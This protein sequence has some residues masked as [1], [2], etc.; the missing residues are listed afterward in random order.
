[1]AKSDAQPPLIQALLTQS[2]FD[3][4]AEARELIETHISWV[5]LAGD[6]VYKIKKP[7]E[8]GF[9]D[10]STLEKRRY[11]CEEELRLNRRLAAD[12]YLEVVAIGGTPE[13][14]Q[15][16]ARRDILEYAVKMRRFPQGAQLD[17][18]L[19]R[20]E[21]DGKK[22]D[23]FARMVADFHGCAAIADA[24]SNFG[25]PP[26]IWQ[27]VEENFIQIREQITDK[28]WQQQLDRLEQWSRDR[29][30][31]LQPIMVQRKRDGFIRECHGDLHLRNLAWIDNRAVAFD[32]I[33]FNPGLSWIDVISDIAFL[34]MDLR[35]KGEAHLAQRFLNG[36]LEISGDYEGL[37]LLSFYL[38]Y[39][40]MVRAKVAALRFGQSGIN[41]SEKNR[42]KNE[43]VVYLN[44]AERCI[45]KGERFLVTTRGVSA[46]GKSKHSSMLLEWLQAIRLRSD[47]ERKRLYG[48]RA[49]ES[50]KA[51]PAE[52]IYSHDASERTYARLKQLAKLTVEA[53]YPVIIDATSLKFEQRE[54]FYQLADELGVPRVLVEFTAPA[55]VLRQRIVKRKK[56]ASDA[57]LQVLEYQLSQWQPVTPNEEPY[58]LSVDTSGPLPE[59]GE[60][61]AALVRDK[62]G[63]N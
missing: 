23:A 56:G 5:I 29:F 45:E 19:Q 35:E 26:R 25:I 49:D 51:N 30:Q 28:H 59:S 16:N 38:V 34:I 13:R 11:N 24:E 12:I 31:Q 33:E 22:I 2:C 50:G 4:P 41:D 55:E 58:R 8:F 63:L 60:R 27:P 43:F 57:D 6:Y 42:A 37:S 21:L 14:P 62:L 47:V 3:H 7:V 9:L 46:S 53:G 48:L 36:Y 17:R 32:C 1:M 54:Q 20:H 10:F 61:L 40:A 44:F 52:G 15:L 39:R 18:M